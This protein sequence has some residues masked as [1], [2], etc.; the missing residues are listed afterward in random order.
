VGF[1]GLF[2]DIPPS[3]IKSGFR[4]FL[5][6]GTLCIRGF[7]GWGLSHIEPLALLALLPHHQPNIQKG[8]NISHP[9]SFRWL[10]TAQFSGIMADLNVAAG[11]A[12][13]AALALVAAA[14]RTVANR[15]VPRTVKSYQSKI[16]RLTLF[17]MGTPSTAHC[18]SNDNVLLLPF[19][20]DVWKLV[21]GWL[22]TDSSLPKKKKKAW[23]A[24]GGLGAAAA[25]P[26]PPGVGAAAAGAPPPDAADDD[27]D[28]DDDDD[29]E[30][31]AIVEDPLQQG[32]GGGGMEMYAANTATISGSCMGNY[33]S[34]IIWLHLHQEVG[35]R[36]NYKPSTCVLL[37]YSYIRLRQVIM[38]VEVNEW[39]NSAVSG[40][41]KQIA[42]K[43]QRGVMDIKE[44]RSQ[45][46]FSGYVTLA[47]TAAK[48]QPLAGKGS[49]NESLFSWLFII[50]CWNMMCRSVNCGGIM[51]QHVTWSND[52]LVVTLPKSK[53]DQSGA[54]GPKSKK[55]QERE[56]YE[57]R[58]ELYQ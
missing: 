21:F 50:L 31:N 11:V 13:L 12:A 25:G 18:V 51:L 3:S 23:G 48:L 39:W 41:K 49:W 17:L 24:A 22:S 35:F 5:V 43:K 26:P 44:G 34:A 55:D 27:D 40:Y 4:G 15:V 2:S 14:N 20:L 58:L 30:A 28:D 32:I 9:P 38:T 7:W 37:F 10:P 52:H 57:N 19:P 53:K 33:K 45:L 16:K 42:D 36:T 29:E 47:E 6:V 1:S 46:Q 56:A 54:E 8:L